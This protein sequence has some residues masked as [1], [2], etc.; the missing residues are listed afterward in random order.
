VTQALDFMRGLSN[1]QPK[2]PLDVM[3]LLESLRADNEAMGRKV[4]ITGFAAK[5]LRGV[6]QMPKRC[7]ANLIDNAVLYGRQAEIQVAESAT[8]LTLRIRDHGPGIPDTELESVFEPFYRL[9]GSRNR[10]SGGTGLGLSIA[11][12]IARAH[13]GDVRLQNCQNGGL[14]TILTLPLNRQ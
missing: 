11:R 12:D 14:E 13:G 10:E 5:P 4:T 3:A 6:P 9:E 8:Q 1:G 7:I 2:Q